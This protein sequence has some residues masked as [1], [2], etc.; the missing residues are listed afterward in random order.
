MPTPGTVLYR[1]LSG[2][3]DSNLHKT[4]KDETAQKYSEIMR[5]IL[6]DYG[7][8]VTWI[9]G[10]AVCIMCIMLLV[11]AQAQGLELSFPRA[12]RSSCSLSWIS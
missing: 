2:F 9:Y 7:T 11:E 8:A 4:S 1:N 3:L 10:A 5:G 12:S 6:M